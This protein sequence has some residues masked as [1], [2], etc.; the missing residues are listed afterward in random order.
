MYKNRGELRFRSKRAAAKRV[1]MLKY[2]GIHPDKQ[3]GYFKDKQEGYFKNNNEMNAH[4]GMGRNP[5]TNTRK[6]H[7]PYR[8]NGGYGR[9]NNYTR[10]DQRQI[11]RFKD[12]MK[13]V[14]A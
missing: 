6:S 4:C 13:E 5:R 1:A 3:D 11:D 8:C 12:M 7:C 14:A 9:A 10:K 2:L